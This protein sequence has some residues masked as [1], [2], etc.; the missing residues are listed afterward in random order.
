[1]SK[2]KTYIY[3]LALAMV[4]IAV[5]YI[6][7]ISPI[8]SFTALCLQFAQH[9]IS[10]IAAAICA[11]IFLGNKNYWFIMA[12][13]AVIT[14]LVVQLVIVG[15]NAEILTWAARIVTFMAIVFV[16]NFVRLVINR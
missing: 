8:K 15:H 12:G 13:C 11:F 14:A 4:V 6:L 16:M 7:N 2:T 1:M 3:I 5:G 10:S 9:N